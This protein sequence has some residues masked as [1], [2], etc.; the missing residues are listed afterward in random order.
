[1]G[2]KA[3]PLTEKEVKEEAKNLE[4]IAAEF[5]GGNQQKAF[6][7]WHK[8]LREIS[9]HGVA[10]AKEV[11]KQVETDK[12]TLAPSLEE[13]YRDE[14]GGHAQLVVQPSTAGRFLRR[15]QYIGSIVDEETIFSTALGKKGTRFTEITQKQK[16]PE[17][18]WEHRSDLLPFQVNPF[19]PRR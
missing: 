11:F 13:V 7:A 10:S 17:N 3:P 9:Q 4:E 14:L 15:T 8:E 6:D 12:K 2:D 18:P 1:M 19:V 16:P 5:A